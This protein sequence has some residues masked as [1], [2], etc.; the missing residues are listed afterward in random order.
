[1]KI[2]KNFIK[3]LYFSIK[4][5]DK[6]VTILRKSN[7]SLNTILCGYNK[8]GSNTFINNSYVDKGT[9]IGSDCYL[10]FVRVGK[11]C[12]I[13]NGVKTIVTTHPTKKFVSTHPAF[14]S[15]KKQAGFTYVKSGKFDE[16]VFLDNNKTS[17]YIGND[18]WIGED[19]KIL[20]GIK[21][22]DGA[23]IGAGAI[24]TKDLEPYG[25]Y[26]GIPAK[27]IGSRFSDEDINFL[28]NFKWWNNSDEWIQRNVDYFDD[29][30]KFREVKK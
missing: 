17:I 8:I 27:K 14:F 2:I 24:V 12:S 6:K 30:K 9:Y 25:I 10:S 26:A 5:F 11:Y 16:I 3:R 22:G 1:M 13:A 4:Y 18:V 28:L 23:I 20:G 29:I 15:T 7:V 19:V 21:I